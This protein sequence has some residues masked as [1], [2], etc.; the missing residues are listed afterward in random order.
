MPTYSG[1]ELT[2]LVAGQ[3]KWR[4]QELTAKLMAQCISLLD[5]LPETIEFN[6]HQVYI[7]ALLVL[8]FGAVPFKRQLEA[9]SFAPEGSDSKRLPGY[10][11]LRSE[12]IVDLAIE[13]VELPI[14]EPYIVL[15]VDDGYDIK[16]DSPE[17]VCGV[18][19][20]L[21]EPRY[22][23]TVAQGLA[24]AIMQPRFFDRHNMYL[25]GSRIKD[26]TTGELFAPDFWVYGGQIKMKRDSPTASDPR[27]VTPSWRGIITL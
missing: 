10:S 23:V 11:F 26:E 24:L 3:I 14:D 16:G 27:W 9:I 20:G 12:N 5:A 8:P 13:A 15:H 17:D 22:P 7:P 25:S 4:K 19:E 21:D 1:R 2:D 18:L 6:Q